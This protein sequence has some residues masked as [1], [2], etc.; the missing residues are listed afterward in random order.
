[1]GYAVLGLDMRICW[2]FE[3]NKLGNAAN[4]G[5]VRRAQNDKG[6]GGLVENKQLQMQ[7]QRQMR[8][9][10]AALWMTRGVGG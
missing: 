9:F 2:D 8:G 10:F 5:I 3:Q 7:K 1:M 4:V 6:L